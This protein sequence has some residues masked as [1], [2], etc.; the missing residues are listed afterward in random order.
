VADRE[1]SW[2]VIQVRG[3]AG[4]PNWCRKRRRESVSSFAALE[5]YLPPVEVLDVKFLKRTDEGYLCQATCPDSQDDFT[6]LV[7]L[8]VPEKQLRQAVTH[9]KSALCKFVLVAAHRRHPQVYTDPDIPAP[10]SG[11]YQPSVAAFRLNRDD[12]SHLV[13]WSPAGDNLIGS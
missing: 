1:L 6:F 10:T 5:A 7:S 9:C 12:I 3:L 2:L 13:E 8:D 11:V 4:V